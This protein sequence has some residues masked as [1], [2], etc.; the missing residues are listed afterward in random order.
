MENNHTSAADIT[1]EKLAIMKMKAGSFERDILSEPSSPTGMRQ[2]FNFGSH[3][4]SND[5]RSSLTRRSSRQV[6]S[7][8]R[9]AST[10]LQS[11]RSKMSMELTS[12]A[13]GKF[14]A[15]MDL[16]STASREASSLKESW[17]MIIAEREALA[18]E[19]EELLIRVE[20]VTETLERQQT[21]HLHHGHEHGERKRHVEKLLVELSTALAAVTDHKKKVADRDH[22][23]ERVRAELTELRTTVARSHGEHDKTKAEIEGLYAKL[24][25]CEADRDS[26]R[27]DSHKHHG[28]LR[29]LLREHTDL[30][31]KHEETY[32]KF[33]STRKEVLSLTDRI[34]IFELER[35]ESLHEKDRLQ[36]ELKRAKARAEEGSRDLISLTERHD[37]V[38][39]DHH[40]VKET[41]RTI[42]SE[43]DE[44]ALSIENLRREV[45]AKATGW[46]E[47]DSRCAEVTL[48]Y[49][50]IKREVISV[51][52][53]LR[54][55]EVERSELRDAIDRSREEHRL[56]IISRDQ[57]IQDLD[58]E[59]RKTVDAYRRITLLEESLHRAEQAASATKSELSTLTERNQLLVHEA[60][61]HKSRHAHLTTDNSELHAQLTT[62][63]AE[64]RSV[65]HACDRAHSDLAAWKHK[66]EEVTE[67]ITSYDDS[68]VEF[69]FE[70]E[71]LRSLLREAREQKERAIQARYSADRERDGAV[72]R[73]EEKCREMER[74]EE[75][76]SAS[77]VFH[78][79]GRSAGGWG[80][81]DGYEDCE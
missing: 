37:R 11:H 29:S 45:K 68:A 34:K 14:F 62:L 6:S 20:E 5:L 7:S 64:L 9:R 59:R 27:Q 49:D 55:L 21:E 53:K 46:E 74:W 73:Y 48:K 13:E 47:S 25:A 41:I 17:A 69:E 54:D 75:S 19:K 61:E 36:D 15:L 57:H 67:T 32:T 39:R 10:F 63:Q 40:K 28:D 80:R 65:T 78:S 76:H 52:E 44:H 26:A 58:D 77:S 35:D 4:H 16:M 3:S 33:E 8:S 31:S 43:R 1:P 18:R 51:K 24:K 72:Q 60:D 38:Q 66:Y 50:H 70:I 42:E 71:S 2:S 56:L 81:E 22:E 30:K 79:G 12:Q 23:L